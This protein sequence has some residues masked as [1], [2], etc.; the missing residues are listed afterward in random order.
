[1]RTLLLISILLTS[2]VTLGQGK[3]PIQTLYKGDSVVILT[4]EQ[5]IDINKA[6]SSQKKIIRE[7]AKKIATL[8]NKVDSLN[9]IIASIPTTL[10]NA[11]DSLQYVADTTLKW[12]EELNLTLWEYATN[13]AFIYV[14]PPDN[15]LYFINLDD[16]NLYSTDYGQSISFQKM[17]K[18]E[19]EEYK[20]YKKEFANMVSPGINYF[21]NFEFA[22][23]E[24]MVRR[25]DRKVWK[26]KNLLKQELKKK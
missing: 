16:Y 25:Y 6:I 12:A 5:S 15:K 20:E 3:Y 18:K 4:T 13:G 24:D 23:F 26:N 8:N 10:T 1:M 9:N 2:V 14:I 11:T 22:D 21:H 19:Y 17:T 7:Q